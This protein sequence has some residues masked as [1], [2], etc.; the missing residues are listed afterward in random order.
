MNRRDFFSSA[1]FLSFGAAALTANPTMA[2]AATLSAPA[3]ETIDALR[4]SAKKRWAAHG[5]DT[6]VV[7]ANGTDIHVAVGGRGSTVVLLHGY[8]QSGEIWRYI[9]PVLAKQY[10]VII[11]DLPGM[12]LS[13]A[14]PGQHSLLA[15]ANDVQALLAALD[16]EQA[17][18]VGH[19]WGAAVG[20]TLALAH[21]DVATK[22]AFIESALAGAG[23][24]QLWRFDKPNPV[25]TFIPFLLMRGVAEALVTGREN[26]FLH[27]L[28]E[29]STTNKQGAPF[30]NW[31]PYVDAISQPGQ[32]SA[33]ADYYRSVYA[34]AEDTRHLLA[35]GKLAIP[36]L[37]IAGAQSFNAGNEKMAQNFAM[38][39][40]AGI[41][42]QNTGHFV[43]EERPRELVAV[44]EPFL[45]T[46]K[47]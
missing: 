2:L 5:F 22:L 3:S 8:P 45:A 37:P 7:S 36:V 14:G 17:A 11:P 16:V 35:Y 23:F 40:R 43:A 26:I 46:A 15:A 41:I 32:F 44:L 28:W 31:A 6:R 20:A 42:F 13:S 30:V 25:L 38:H 27:H 9:A 29:A 10:R 4:Q 18:I 34:S 12:G 21:R 47:S 39:V 19:D 1:A 24:E 33:S